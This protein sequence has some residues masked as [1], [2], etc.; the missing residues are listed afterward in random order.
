MPLLTAGRFK[1]IAMLAIC[2]LCGCGSGKNSQPLGQQ[3]VEAAHTAF[4]DGI[5]VSLS[6]DSLQPGGSLAGI[7]LDL[8][9]AADGTLT[10]DIGVRDAHELRA[11]YL[12]IEYDNA[13]WHPQVCDVADEFAARG[14][15]LSVSVLDTPGVVH[16]G[17]LLAGTDSKNT[18]S[19]SGVLASLYLR[20]GPQETMRSAA[21]A[22]TGANSSS[23]IS[24]AFGSTFGLFW[25][26]YNQGDY[27]QNGLVNISDLTPLGIRLGESGPFSP[28]SILGVVDGDGNGQI[29]ISDITPIGVNFG[30]SIASFNIYASDDIADYPAAGG[31]STIEPYATKDKSDFQ[32][33]DEEHHAGPLANEGRLFYWG[34][35]IA[36]SIGDEDY[37]YYWV[38]PTDG[39]EEGTPSQILASPFYSEFFGDSLEPPTLSIAGMDGMGEYNDPFIAMPGAEY[40]VSVIDPLNGDI[41]TDPEMRYRVVTENGT[42]WPYASISSTD[43]ILRI[44][45][46]APAGNEEL[47]LQYFV[48]ALNYSQGLIGGE[49]YQ[50]G[51]A[52]KLLK[53]GEPLGKPLPDLQASTV[54]GP[55]PLTVQFDAS[56]STSPNG[57]I[58]FHYWKFDKYGGT[59][60]SSY[61]AATE[62]TFEQPG[63]YVVNLEVTDDWYQTAQVQQIITVLPVGS[64][65]LASILPDMTSGNIPVTITFSAEY[66]RAAAG[67]SIAKYEWDLDDNE[68]NGYEVDSGTDP[69]VQME[70]TAG[71]GSFPVRVLVTDSEAATASATTYIS[72]YSPAEKSPVIDLQIDTLAGP[73]PLTVNF[74]ASASM[75]P[76]GSI[77]RWGWDFDGDGT[78]ELSDVSDPVAGPVASF[79]YA[80]GG[81]FHGYFYVW[82]DDDNG[83]SKEFVIRT[84]GAPRAV[85]EYPGGPFFSLPVTVA[86][87]ASN[88]TDLDGSIVEY[89]WDYNGDMNTDEVTA[90]SKVSH[91]FTSSGS[92]LVIVTVV[93]DNGLTD[94]AYTS[95]TI[96]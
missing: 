73:S 83:A 45:A 33:P 4:S 58:R 27:D 42:P 56:G 24:F 9:H 57:N 92:Q 68:G 78:L 16:H 69:Q 59:S 48:G 79:T 87:D 67:R 34:K 94:W 53:S 15:L 30:A 10:A 36:Q 63:V 22:P 80:A 49:P 32:T 2:F 5:R 95:F 72:V 40:Q 62:F 54:E 91:E 89:R 77:A 74:D 3:P 88:S 18:Y 75:D 28:A 61:E 37:N 26:Y 6:S 8:Q 23:D 52:G 11:L 46:D 76:D 21:K 93:D 90:T 35:I 65:P 60:G 1:F 70:Y 43:A 55:A 31:P 47:H 7:S 29:N 12:D 17:Q 39:V 41:S 44:A 71:M 82:D 20:P 38:R 51:P 19:G 50:G 14:E 85:L 96:F 66:S 25:H 86:L 84:D 13:L 64:E 81:A